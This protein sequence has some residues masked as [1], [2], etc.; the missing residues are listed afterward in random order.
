MQEL[1][2][3]DIVFVLNNFARKDNQFYFHIK[4]ASFKKEINNISMNNKYV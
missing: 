4:S 1:F 3:P 2:D